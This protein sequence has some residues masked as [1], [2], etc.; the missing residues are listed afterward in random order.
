MPWLPEDGLS[1]GPSDKSRQAGEG[2]PLTHK[3]ADF[4]AKRL[5]GIHPRPEGSVWCQRGSLSWDC[6]EG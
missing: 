2:W 5:P 6:I 3:R 1:A 4:V